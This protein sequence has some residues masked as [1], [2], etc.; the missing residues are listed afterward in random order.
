VTVS[1]N[2]G[3]T[4]TFSDL[5]ISGT[6]GSR[7]LLFS[8]GAL[9]PV[10]SN[11]INLTTGPAASINIQDGDTQSAPVGTAVPTDPAVII[12]D[13]GGNPVG[14]VAASGDGSATPTPVTTGGDGIAETTWTLGTTAGPNQLTATASVGTVTFNATATAGTTTT[15]TVEPPSTTTSGTQVTFTR[16]Q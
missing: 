8:S 6:V 7:T 15:L 13:S 16:G 4:A 9:T 5:A 12:R 1:T 14:G 10:E 2:G 3:S 11:P